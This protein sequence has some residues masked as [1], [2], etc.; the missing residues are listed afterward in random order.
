MAAAWKVTEDRHIGSANARRSK[1]D[2]VRSMTEYDIKHGFITKEETPRRLIARRRTS[3][4]TCL[5]T[6]AQ[7]YNAL[8][9]LRGV[10]A[11]AVVLFHV[12][13]TNHLTESN[14]IRHGFLMVDLFFMLSGFVLAASYSHRIRSGAEFYRFVRLR[15]FRIYPLHI[16]I[17]ALMVALEVAK[18]A[19]RWS[20][21]MIP[22]RQPFSLPNS[23]VDIL[24][25][26]FLVHSLGTTDHLSWNSPSWS[27]SCEA[28]GYIV[29]ALGAFIGALGTKAFQ[30]IAVPLA[31]AGYA[32]IITYEGTLNVTYDLGIVRCL[33]GLLLGIWAYNLTRTTRISSLEESTLNVAAVC[34]IAW[35]GVTL[36]F[37][38]GALDAIVIP[39]F[40]VA[41]LCLHQDR[42]YAAKALSCRPIAFLGSI[43]YS[44]YMTHYFIIIVFG[45]LIKRVAS[46]S[47]Y[48]ADNAGLLQLTMNPW[49]GDGLLLGAIALIIWVASHT[50]SRIEKPWR[51]YGRSHLGRFDPR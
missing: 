41:L 31:V 28:A 21:L 12:R 33:A 3:D 43:S 42:G 7:R 45:M 40:V 19:G 36:S 27:I 4:K 8:D 20:G 10:A 2:R 29:F 16:V 50:Y 14:L 13:W 6:T 23:F 34:V 30:M 9:G 39:G 26:V 51:E 38:S 22:V 44:V 37:A 35:L 11:L 5:S 15:F 46:K 49:L 17:L 24:L 48:A 1:V 25:N 32:L 47:S 18:V